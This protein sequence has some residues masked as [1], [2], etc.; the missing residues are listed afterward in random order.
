MRLRLLAIGLVLLAGCSHSYQYVS[1]TVG[2]DGRLSILTSDGVTVQPPL[3][4]G[5]VGFAGPV[6]STDQRAVGWLALYPNDA[7]TYPIPLELVVLSRGRRRELTSER[8]IG[9]WAFVDSSKTV[10]FASVPV[11]GDGPTTYE[12]HD[13]A[14]GSLLGTYDAAKDG[15]AEPAWVRTVEAAHQ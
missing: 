8:M 2:T 1:A 14:T 11:H 6:V 3:A 9:D 5:Q 13:V 10:A 15:P 4:K 12:L 7:T